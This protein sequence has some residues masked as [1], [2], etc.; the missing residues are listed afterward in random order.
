[1]KFKD[2][3][4]FEAAVS[5]LQATDRDGAI[6]ELVNSLEKAGKIQKDNTKSIIKAIIKAVV[7]MLSN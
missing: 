2:F 6:E 5:H 3:I 1:M 4:C 7:N